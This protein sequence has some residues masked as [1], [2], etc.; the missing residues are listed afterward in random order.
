MAARDVALR[1]IAKHGRT[2]GVL[3]RPSADATVNPARPWAPGDSNPAVDPIVAQGLAVVVL[4]IN[5]YRKTAGPDVAIN[6]AATAVAL[7][8]AASGAEPRVSDTLESRGTRYAV[9]ASDLL[10]PGDDDV[11]YTLQLKA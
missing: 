7:I 4:D 2:D 5:T 6:P 8:A 10:A 11:L 1:L 9:L 3:R